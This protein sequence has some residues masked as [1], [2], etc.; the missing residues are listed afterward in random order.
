MTGNVC[1][2]VIAEC[3]YLKGMYSIR[4]LELSLIL[5]YCLLNPKVTEKTA[6]HIFTFSLH[7]L[8]WY[9]FSEM[10]SGRTHKNV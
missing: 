1:V 7:V 9:I 2:C 5:V 8:L 10:C 3:T 6:M 4:V